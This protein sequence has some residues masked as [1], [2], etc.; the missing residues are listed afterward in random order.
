MDCRSG[1]YCWR[2][3]TWSY[4]GFLPSGSP[5]R[6]SMPVATCNFCHGERLDGD[7]LRCFA[8][9]IV[10]AIFVNVAL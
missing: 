6:T 7:S 9:V 10:L 4:F 1:L 5:R 8:N 2:R 3:V